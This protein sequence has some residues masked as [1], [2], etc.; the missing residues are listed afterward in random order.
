M[1]KTIKYV[2][3][4][5]ISLGNFYANKNEAIKA[6][7]VWA[8]ILSSQIEL[9]NK[10]G[11]NVMDTTKT[12][13]GFVGSMTPLIDSV[14][15]CETLQKMAYTLEDYFN[16]EGADNAKLVFEKAWEI[17]KAISVRMPQPL[18]SMIPFMFYELIFGSKSDLALVKSRCSEL[19]ELINKYE[20][21]I[22]ERETAGKLETIDPLYPLDSNNRTMSFYAYIKGFL[23]NVMSRYFTDA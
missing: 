10:H 3:I 8:E 16:S 4:S 12:S 23:S 1:K 14:L 6:L 20:E 18:F 22:S 2:N 21:K 5:Q 13:A 17:I 15:V 7:E 19:I 11:L 9:V